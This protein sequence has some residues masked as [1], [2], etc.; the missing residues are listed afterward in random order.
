M[1]CVFAS[2][3]NCT[4][5]VQIRFFFLVNIFPFWTK[6]EYY[7]AKLRVPL[8]YGKTGISKKSEFGHL[9]L[10]QKVFAGIEL[11]ILNLREQK[12]SLF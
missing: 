9:S 3:T 5:S 2:S 1:F 7:P 6:H 4:K 11:K 10:S 12:T 8:K